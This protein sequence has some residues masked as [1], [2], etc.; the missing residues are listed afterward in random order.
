VCTLSGRRE[1]HTI[2][3]EFQQDPSGVL[4]CGS[5]KAGLLMER[6]T[7]PKKMNPHIVVSRS[8]PPFTDVCAQFRTWTLN[9]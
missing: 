4:E 2:A 9:G 3:I 6:Y 7:G 1:T 8:S 5:A